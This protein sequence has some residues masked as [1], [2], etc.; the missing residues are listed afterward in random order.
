M[1]RCCLEELCALWL[2]GANRHDWP[3][4]NYLL[5]AYYL[6]CA[7]LTVAGILTPSVDIK[8]L[9]YPSFSVSSLFYV[10]QK[11]GEQKELCPQWVQVL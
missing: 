2:T 8:A 1:G 9:Q 3:H 5:H 11:C 4:H 6:S 7:L 10:A